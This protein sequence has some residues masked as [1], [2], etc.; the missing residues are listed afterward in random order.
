MK[1]YNYHSDDIIGFSG[2]EKFYEKTLKGTH[3]FD[4]FLVDRLGI[5]QSRYKSI[6][7]SAWTLFSSRQPLLKHLRSFLL[8]L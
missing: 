4:F 3:G 5:I 1:I 7:N 2:V 8:N 6:N